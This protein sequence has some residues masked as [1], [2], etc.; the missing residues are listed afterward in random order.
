[1]KQLI[2]IRHTA[3]LLLLAA[4]YSCAH[5]VPAL[6]ADYGDK[7]AIIVRVHD[8]DSITVSVPDWPG[9]V[10]N[11]I[12]VR[13]YGVDTPELL[14]K[15]A[16]EKAKALLAKT[17][18]ANFVNAKPVTLKTIKRDKYFRI[19]A[20]VYVGDNSLADELIKANLGKSYFGGTKSDWCVAQ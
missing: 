10:G 19:L 4:L 1:M 2:L 6:A 14:G 7:D 16:N 11:K 17:F 5:P 15:C 18:T 12:P 20:N 13:V 3:V 8:G 9:I